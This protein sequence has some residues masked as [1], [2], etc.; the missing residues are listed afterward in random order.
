MDCNSISIY[1]LIMADPALAQA[2]SNAR[3]KTATGEAK[4]VRHRISTA[5]PLTPTERKIR[6]RGYARKWYWKHHQQDAAAYTMT[7]V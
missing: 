7:L 4:P 5:R 3:S 2:V 6:Q 1:D